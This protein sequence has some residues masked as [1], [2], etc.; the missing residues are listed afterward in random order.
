M[1]GHKPHQSELHTHGPDC[2]HA[3]IEHRGH[4]D[5][6][7]DGRLDHVQGGETQAHSIE[8]TAKNPAAC[9]PSHAC[10]AHASEHKHGP[11]C[12]HSPVPHGDHLD[13]VVKDHLHHPCTTHCDDHGP[14]AIQ[15]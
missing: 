8:V 15:N 10:G 2:G 11:S 14:V 1:S 5:Y 9:T 13:Y 12:G 3:V 6:V 4:Q 7:N